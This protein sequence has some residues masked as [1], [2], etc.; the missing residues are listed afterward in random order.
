MFLL[1]TITSA[2]DIT[3]HFMSLPI[4]LGDKDIIHRWNFETPYTYIS[5]CEPFRV[6]IHGGD[7]SLVL[8]YF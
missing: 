4:A 2:G 3:T 1:M 6:N 8:V 7:I 5:R